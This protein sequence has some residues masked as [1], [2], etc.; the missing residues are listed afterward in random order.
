MSKGTTD[1]RSE[2]MF[3]YITQKD[4]KSHANKPKPSRL[5]HIEYGSGFKSVV[6]GFE[7]LRKSACNIVLRHFDDWN[8]KDGFIVIGNSQGGLIARSII[9][10]CHSKIT[11][12]VK[13]LILVGVP[14]MGVSKIPWVGKGSGYL[15]GNYVDR[16]VYKKFFLDN[17]APASYFKSMSKLSFGSWKFGNFICESRILTSFLFLFRKHGGV[18]RGQNCL[19]Q[20]E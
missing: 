4:G 19:G 18:P 16:M 13:R 2:H 20:I 8:L 9:S 15:L 17:C 3:D 11:A 12:N 5:H 14:N 1:S 7:K 6:T 10:E